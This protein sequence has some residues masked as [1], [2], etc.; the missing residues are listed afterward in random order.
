MIWVCEQ[1]ILKLI[2]GKL[3]VQYI[4]PP[5]RSPSPHQKHQP[6]GEG[7]VK[8]EAMEKTFWESLFNNM[9]ILKH[10]MIVFLLQKKIQMLKFLY[11]SVIEKEEVKEVVES[12]EVV[13]R[14]NTTKPEYVIF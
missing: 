10:I 13:N 12:E 6:N 14:E 9:W 4:P 8:L 5:V 1:A 2:M 3:G 11:F 7:N